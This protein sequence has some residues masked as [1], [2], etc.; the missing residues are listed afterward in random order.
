MP[1]LGEKRKTEFSWTQSNQAMSESSISYGRY[2][3]LHSFENF[4][5]SNK[6]ENTEM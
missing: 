4:A 5:C 3:I 1:W 2:G 6:Q